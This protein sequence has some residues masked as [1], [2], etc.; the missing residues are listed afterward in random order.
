M[1]LTETI[2]EHMKTALKS[3]EKM[4]L[5]LL[6]SLRASIIEFEKSGAGRAMTPKDEQDI[7]LKAA[8]KRKE[9]IEIYINAGR[10]DA[11]EQER[12][13]LA[14]IQ[15]FLPKQLSDDEVEQTVRDI[16]TEQGASGAGDF[17]R[18]M[19]AAMQ[20]LRGKADGALVQSTVKKLLA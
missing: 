16:I 7:L 17:A 11:A 10:A 12:A 6:R 14:I 8:K 18:V 9:A 13:E 1:S 15:E 4:R 5:A 3:G 20:T 2:N 19:G